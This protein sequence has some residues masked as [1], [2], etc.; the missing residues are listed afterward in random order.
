LKDTVQRVHM[1]ERECM[2][3]WERRSKLEC[4]IWYDLLFWVESWK[5]QEKNTPLEEASD[6][7]DSFVQHKHHE[8]ERVEYFSVWNRV[9]VW[10]RVREWEWEWEW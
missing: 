7:R 10:M 1:R 4:L 8:T 2:R 3:I 6:R 5:D 9:S